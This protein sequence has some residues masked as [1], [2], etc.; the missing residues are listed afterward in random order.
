MSETDKTLINIV[1]DF[2]LTHI[3]KMEE[4]ALGQQSN[5]QEVTHVKETLCRIETKLDS[6]D[7]KLDEKDTALQLSFSERERKW[8]TKYASKRV[9]VAVWSCAGV[10]L[11]ALIYAI[12][13]QV[14]IK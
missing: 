7:K 4:L 1:R 11:L 10:M 12:M 3:K 6:L 8:D 14:I 5:K 2:E 13:N 9:E